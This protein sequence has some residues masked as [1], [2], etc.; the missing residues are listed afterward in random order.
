MANDAAL[1]SVFGSFLD[2]HP[3]QGSI[4]VECSTVAPT[5]TKKLAERAEQARGLQLC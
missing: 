2:G 4:F 3:Q 5:L 1:E